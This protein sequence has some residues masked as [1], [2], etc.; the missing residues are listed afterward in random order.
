M[1]AKSIR[2][3]G[4]V[5]E[6]RQQHLQMNDRAFCFILGAGASVQ[7]GIPSGASFVKQWI[8]ELHVQEDFDHLNLEE[9][10]D[11]N[12]GIPN[13]DYQEAASFYA[14]IYK[15]R[16]Q[17]DPEKGYAFLEDAMN[18][19]EPSYGYIV[20]AQILSKTRHKVVITTNFDNLV[21]DALSIYTRTFPL[22][23]GHESLAGFVRPQLRGPLIAKIHRDLLLEPI[24]TPEGTGT[25][26][27]GWVRALTDILQF[28]TPIVIGYGGN[29]G[30]LMDFLVSLEI[31]IKGGIFW[32]HLANNNPDERVHQVVFKHRGRLVPVVGFDEIMLLLQEQLADNPSFRDLQHLPSEI[33]SRARDR[34]L[35]YR[36]QFE[37]LLTKVKEPGSD[38]AAER[39]KAPVRQAAAAAVER[40]KAENDWWAW[41]LKAQTE[42]D[43]EKKEM[44]Y[45]EGLRDLPSSPELA[46][47][48]A[49]FM[50]TVRKNYDEAERLYRRA[51]DLDPN[52]AD[53]TGNF[54]LFLETVRKDN[55][56][57]ERLYRRALDLDPNDANTARNFA[58]FMQT[59]RQNYDEAER[60]YR[61]ALELDPN[62]PDYIGNFALF[63]AT[64]QRYEEAEFLYRRALG[65]D[66]TN[67]NN[68]RNFAL[69]METIVKDYDEAERLYRRALE[70]DPNQADYI[71]NFALFMQT[72]RKDYDEAERLYRRALD[73]DPNDAGHTG[74]F[75]F[76]MQIVREDYDE[77]ER[78]YRRAL[79]LDPRDADHTGNLAFFMQA[80][81]KVY[82]EAVQ[83]YITALALDPDHARNASNFANFMQAHPEIEQKHRSLVRETIERLRR[84]RPGDWN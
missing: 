28:Y 80:I 50:E 66:P 35:A 57:A 43:P 18:D 49:L 72:I 48:F 31:P 5:E 67:A 2:I 21:A 64:R 42:P 33:E 19:K 37:T 59:V 83:L 15:R 77:A 55:D 79:N 16:F 9:W 56:E 24:S 82:D 3:Q 63:L 54:A 29:D 25:L 62:N 32:C 46:G 47:N 76:F 52:Q 73:L 84:S 7:S 41:D 8:R 4:F 53:Y 1:Q 61:R 6:F 10:A 11:Q 17:D 71:G 75:A 22:V 20:L 13:F 30:S 68:V 58:L 39:A 44:I 26:A 65:L 40:I 74:N 70:L 69:F 38:D 14:E 12:L 36:K 27:L 34:I 45:R 23:C 81:R 78:L 51:L 60:L